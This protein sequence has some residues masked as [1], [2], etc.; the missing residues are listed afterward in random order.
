[1]KIRTTKKIKRAKIDVL[2]FYGKVG[3]KTALDHKND[4]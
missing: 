3:V 2:F 1:M 4:Y